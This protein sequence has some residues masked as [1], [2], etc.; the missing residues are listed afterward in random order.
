MVVGKNS[1]NL[2][3]K[4]D[5]RKNQKKSRPRRRKEKKRLSARLPGRSRSET[6]KSWRLG[7][8]MKASNI[9]VKG[10]KLQK[11]RINK[12]FLKPGR[13]LCPLRRRHPRS[14]LGKETST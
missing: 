14:R 7:D 11:E 13:K 10:G 5:G 1:T 3:Q 2:V 12:N 9:G 6:M 8:V 4:K